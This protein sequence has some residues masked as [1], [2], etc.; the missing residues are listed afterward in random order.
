MKVLVLISALLI[1]TELASS[2]KFNYSQI[3]AS[4]ITAIEKSEQSFLFTYDYPISVSTDYFP[5]RQKYSLAQ[6][7]MY[8]TSK[9]KFNFEK[10]YYF[11]KSDS[12]VRLVEYQWEGTDSSSLQ[13][14]EFVL[15]QNRKILNNY[16]NQA[17]RQ[18]PETETKAPKDIWENKYVYVEQFYIAGL[19]KIRVLISWK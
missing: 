9:E 14:F 4:D 10:S 13:D 7:L 2:Q 8:R 1:T 16:F 15:Q 19:L 3:K 17:A 6:P 18:I 12:V 5:N 11:S